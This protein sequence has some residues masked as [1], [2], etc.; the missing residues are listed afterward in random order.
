ES[1]A[2][3]FRSLWSAS[4]S[5]TEEFKRYEKDFRNRATGLVMGYNTRSYQ[6]LRAGYRFGKNFDSDFQLLTGSASYKV[7][8]ELSVE[9]ELQRLLLDPDP[10][11]ETTWIHVAR[12][13]HFF[14]NDLFIR[15]FFQTNSA[16]D[17]RNL[18]AVFVWRYLPPFGTIQIAFQRGTAEFGLPSE[19]GN[20]LFI[21]AT[22]VF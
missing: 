9:Y 20:T 17:R 3:E 7:T 1:L 18:Q 22:K 14:T 15:L 11:D 5:H 4:L 10:D 8:P 2:F 21:K 16:I 13:S 19:Q 12:A 6:S